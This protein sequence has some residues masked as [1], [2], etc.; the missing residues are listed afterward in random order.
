[1][2][3]DPVAP[4]FG[5]GHARVACAMGWGIVLSK[6]KVAAARMLCCG[7]FS[8]RAAFNDPLTAF[9]DPRGCLRV[10]FG[11]ARRRSKSDFSVGFLFSPK[12]LLAVKR[13]VASAQPQ[14]TRID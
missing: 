7:A 5:L 1:M 11:R 2:P 10:R 9:G 13:F 3:T 14:A 6:L 12:S 8:W 4:S